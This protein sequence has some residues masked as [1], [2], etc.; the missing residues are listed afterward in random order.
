[1]K[2]LNFTEQLRSLDKTAIHEILNLM[3][4]KGVSEVDLTNQNDKYDDVY[5]YRFDDDGHSANNILIVK[6]IS[7]EYK[8][9]TYL[10]LIDDDGHHH[11]A[12]DFHEGTFPYIYNAVFAHLFE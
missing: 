7:E 3:E 8:G 10:T 4:L 11:T 5:A 1:M 9:N 6:A 2:R 12:L